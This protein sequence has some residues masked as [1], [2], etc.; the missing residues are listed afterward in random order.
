MNKLIHTYKFNYISTAANT[1]PFDMIGFSIITPTVRLL[2]PSRVI[3][4]NYQDTL[5]YTTSIPLNTWHNEVIAGHELAISDKIR[6][7]DEVATLASMPDASVLLFLY[8]DRVQVYRN[9]DNVWE[10]LGNEVFLVPDASLLEE[11]ILPVCLTG[12]SSY[13]YEMVMDCRQNGQIADGHFGRESKTTIRLPLVMLPGDQ[14]GT[15]DLATTPLFN[16]DVIERFFLTDD[17]VEDMFPASGTGKYAIF[18]VFYDGTQSKCVIYY[19]VNYSQSSD[20]LVFTGVSGR[21]LPVVAGSAYTLLNNFTLSAAGGLAESTQYDM[22]SRMFYFSKAEPM[23]D[24]D[25]IVTLNTLSLTT[26]P[27]MVVS[28][29]DVTSATHVDYPGLPSTPN[30]VNLVLDF[31]SE[32]AYLTTTNN[33]AINAC[34]AGCVPDDV[35]LAGRWQLKIYPIEGGSYISVYQNGVFIDSVYTSMFEYNISHIPRQ[36]TW[37]VN[38]PVSPISVHV[39]MQPTLNEVPFQHEPDLCAAVALAGTLTPCMSDEDLRADITNHGVVYFDLDTTGSVVNN[40]TLTSTSVDSTWTVTNNTVPCQITTSNILSSGTKSLFLTNRSVITVAPQAGD[41]TPT[42]MFSFKW[43]IRPL[44]ITS[45]N[46]FVIEDIPLLSSEFVRGVNLRINNGQWQVVSSRRALT[47]GSPTTLIMHPQTS[48]PPQANVLYCIG[49]TISPTSIVLYINGVA[50]PCSD[51]NLHGNTRLFKVGPSPRNRLVVTLTASMDC[52][53][54]SMMIAWDTMWTSTQMFALNNDPSSRAL[55]VN[56]D[57]TQLVTDTGKRALALPVIASSYGGSVKALRVTTVYVDSDDI[58]H[59]FSLISNYGSCSIDVTFTSSTA[60][61]VDLLY[62]FD[63]GQVYE[64]VHVNMST[65]V[66]GIRL[67]RGMGLYIK[68]DIPVTARMVAIY[69]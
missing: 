52:F 29:H 59:I 40:S 60:G 37:Y 64:A 8:P 26:R 24:I 58:V 12:S 56:C 57:V 43:Y 35:T 25:F 14:A 49:I 45:G 39:S 47:T 21:V 4:L 41:T 53:L 63:I 27:Y 48:P 33:V 46:V 36:V 61:T 34:T 66:R 62:G 1:V 67:S 5:V 17:L 54:D 50:Y 9:L 28:F 6:V 44:N 42:V 55:L 16:I 31:A 18:H 2:I 15:L 3:S 20:V 23:I 10:T 51:A 19:G 30:G 22:Q 7:T 11:R 13:S 38:S 65:T 69:M 68:S 32:Q